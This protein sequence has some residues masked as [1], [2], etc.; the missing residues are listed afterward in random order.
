MDAFMGV[1]GRIYQLEKGDIATLPERNAE[2]LVERNIALNM[3]L[4]K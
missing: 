1:D 2:V 4:S 3:I